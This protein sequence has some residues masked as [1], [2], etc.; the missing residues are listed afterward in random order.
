MACKIEHTGQR[1]MGSVDN[2]VRAQHATNQT[3]TRDTSLEW[4]F[5]AAFFEKLVKFLHIP[6]RFVRFQF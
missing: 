4:L 1:C 2:S 3:S 5:V 6:L